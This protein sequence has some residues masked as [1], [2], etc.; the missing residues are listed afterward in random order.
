MRKLRVRHEPL[1]GIG[2]LFEIVAASGL[3]VRVASYRSGRRDVAIGSPDADE[4]EVTVALTR[5]EADR[6][7]SAARWSPHRAD[8]RAAGLKRPPPPA[9]D[10]RPPRRFRRRRSRAH[11]VRIAF[12]P[13]GVHR[14]RPARRRGHRVGRRADRRCHGGNARHR[15]GGVGRLAGTVDRPAPRRLRGHDVADRRRR[16][17]SRSSSTPAATS[18]PTQPTWVGSPGCWSSSPDRCSA[19]SRPT[20]C[21]CS[22][23]AG[24]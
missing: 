16:S 17:A 15:T 20:T 12:G 14:G 2:E 22:T 10:D 11:R 1:P 23:R 6:V 21:W 7:G 9:V 18:R 19:S 5:A 13:H 8:H 24:S 3:S 4:P